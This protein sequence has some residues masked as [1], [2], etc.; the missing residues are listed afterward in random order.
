MR[1]R[2]RSKVD[3]RD[4]AAPYR[5]VGL[6]RRCACNHD[7][8]SPCCSV[9][10]DNGGRRKYHIGTAAEIRLL[11]LTPI[12]STASFGLCSP[13]QSGSPCSSASLSPNHLAQSATM[14]RLLLRK[15]SRGPIIRCGSTD[16]PPRAPVRSGCAGR[17]RVVAAHQL[18]EPERVNVVAFSSTLCMY[19]DGSGHR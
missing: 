3:Q 5:R 18:A 4:P 7:A 2:L 1:W 12:L 19:G 14:S 6:R 13:C 15:S 8:R 10:L 16:R 9:R 11:L 17:V